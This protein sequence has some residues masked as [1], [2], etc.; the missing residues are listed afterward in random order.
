MLSCTLEWKKQTVQ[1]IEK[2]KL[3]MKEL[4]F[5]PKTLT[6]LEVVQDWF[7]HH[8]SDGEKQRIEII[9]AIMKKPDTL[10]MDE[11]TSRVDHDAKT[12]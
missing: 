5:K 9:S 1:E 11:A 6:D 7:G 4:G 8:L 10:F 12:K 2:I 3:L